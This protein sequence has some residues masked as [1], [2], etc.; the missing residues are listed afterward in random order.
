MADTDP[1]LSVLDDF[2]H[3]PVVAFSSVFPLPLFFHK[4]CP[5][6]ISGTEPANLPVGNLGK[7]FADIAENRDK[8]ISVMGCQF[9]I[10]GEID[11]VTQFPAID[12]QTNAEL[13]EVRSCAV[14]EHQGFSVCVKN[15]G[16]PALFPVSKPCLEF[17]SSD[18]QPLCLCQGRRLPIGSLQPPGAALVPFPHF[19]EAP[20]P[21]HGQFRLLKEIGNH[22]KTFCYGRQAPYGGFRPSASFRRWQ[23]VPAVD[24]PAARDPCRVM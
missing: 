11:P 3:E 22:R 19:S 12:R 23:D 20:E 9:R 15:T 2:R 21:V 16:S 7:G 4:E 13:F 18:E 10:R 17:R 14:V 8:A 6:V 24:M 5:G 1:A